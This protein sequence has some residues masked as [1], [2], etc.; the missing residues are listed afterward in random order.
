MARVL[1]TGGAGFVGSHLVDA[2]LEAGHAVRVLDNLDP[3]AH[4]SGAPRFLSPEAELVEAD[5]RHSPAVARALRGVE[6]VLHQAGMVGNG[7][8][9]Y[10]IHRYVDVNSGG[11]AVLLEEVLRARDS[12]RRVVTASSM[13]VYGE[14]AYRC[15]EHGVVAPGLRRR[16]DL[17]ARR[18]EN[19]CPRCGE[20]VEPVPT[21]EDHPL[22]PTSPYAISKRDCEELTLTTGH[23]HGLET[24]ALRYLNVYG[25][26]QALS[27]PYT[28]VA[29]IF[30]TR[31][32]G[33]R[34]PLVFED[35]RQ[36]RDL[37]HVSDVVRA[38]LLAMDAPGVVGLPVNVGTGVS[39][40]VRELA[41]VLAAELGVDL[42]PEVT[43]RFRAGDIRHCVADVRRA[44]DLLG[45]EARAVRSEALRDLARWVAGETPVDRTVAAV[46]ALRERGLIR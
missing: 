29:A 30:S 16:A 8:S 46:A 27:N 26:R 40:T 41:L 2:L 13:V 9:M 31:L 18:W 1:V 5:L 7:Q 3:Q 25:P 24:V 28:G 37:V 11:T 43:R 12:V 33:G 4:E 22:Q 38:N 44:R 6:V 36:R 17:D 14:G 23:A 15:A 35:G 39:I 45:F 10:E 34:R 19:R 42:E 32:L 21:S 20:A